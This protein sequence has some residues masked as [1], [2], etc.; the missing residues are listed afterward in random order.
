MLVLGAASCN[1]DAESGECGVNDPCERGQTCQLEEAI[2]VEV[3]APTGATEDP[4]PPTFSAKYVPFHRGTLCVALQAQSG[5]PF[6]VSL[7][8]CLHPCVIPTS[9]YFHNQWSCVGSRCEAFAALWMETRSAAEG[10]PADAF[11]A[12]DPGLCTTP[13]TADLSINPRYTN[14]DLVIGTMSLEVPFMSN[15]EAELVAAASDA[16]ISEAV[17]SVIQSYP[18]DPGRM[19]PDVGVT[20]SPDN[21]LP[22]ATCSDSQAACD[23]F[24]IGF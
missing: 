22:P 16:G 20:L 6:P 24:P 19:V 7:T 23:C 12:F 13:V 4:A 14:G 3:G 18:S 8:P 10:C 17:A 15:A 2:C 11:G 5:E 21:P 1:P 9:Q